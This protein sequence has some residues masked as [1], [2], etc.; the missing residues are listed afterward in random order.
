MNKII[1][2]ETPPVTK[3]IKVRVDCNGIF[4]AVETVVIVRFPNS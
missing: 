3:E 1:T 4:L 2:A